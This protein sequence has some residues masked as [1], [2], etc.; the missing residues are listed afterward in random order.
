[1]GG[2]HSCHLRADAELRIRR[3]IFDQISGVCTASRRSITQPR[4]PRWADVDDQVMAR[5]RRNAREL[6]RLSRGPCTRANIRTPSLKSVIAPPTLSMLTTLLLAAL[7]PLVA[8]RPAFIEWGD[9]QGFLYPVLTPGRPPRLMNGNAVA[10]SSVASY[11]WTFGQ[12]QVILH[13]PAD[14]TDPGEWCIDAG[15]G[16]SASH[17]RF[18]SDSSPS[19][20]T[21]KLPS[22]DCQN[23]RKAPVSRSG[24]ATA[25]RRNRHG[26]SPT[27][28]SNLPAPTCA[29][30]YRV[31]T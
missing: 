19:S 25:A 5:H 6:H 13:K 29:W 22:A 9:R 10:I 24:D 27:A 8:A 12:N 4:P 7:V 21:S 14:T 11:D 18:A 23:P 28:R 2:A 15:L 16:E 30:T 26:T 3:D 1:M 20:L 31:G 17:V